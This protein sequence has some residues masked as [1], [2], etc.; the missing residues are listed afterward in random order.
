M[1]R[2]A[3]H[4]G[5][6]ARRARGGV[7]AGTLSEGEGAPN[8]GGPGAAPGVD[9]LDDPCSAGPG[10]AGAVRLQDREQSVV[11]PAG[12]VGRRIE[13]RVG[14]PG[15]RAVDQRI[16]AAP[17]LV[18]QPVGKPGQPGVE[19]A[20]PGGADRSGAGGF[21]ADRAEHDRRAG[22]VGD[23]FQTRQPR[24]IG[25]FIVVELGD[26]GQALTGGEAGVARIGDAGLGGVDVDQGAGRVAAKGV[27]EVSRPGL[28]GI[29]RNDD[30]VRA[31]GLGEDAF[32]RAPKGLIAPEGRYEDRDRHGRRASIRSRAPAMVRTSA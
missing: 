8:Q 1:S 10:E 29:V 18:R 5:A 27:D 11:L 22:R 32:Q 3:A 7:L 26:P 31:A 19:P 17:G 21:G 28:R 24:R 14:K 15:A 4:A 12:L 20:Q 6:P 16:A 25:A 30:A 23:R 13:G 2:Q 9:M